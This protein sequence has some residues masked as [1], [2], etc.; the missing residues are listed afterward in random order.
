MFL[1]MKI[2]ETT[3]VKKRLAGNVLIDSKTDKAIEELEKGEIRQGTVKE[4]MKEI[5]KSPFISRV[6]V[7]C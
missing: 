6:R 7:Y 5:M 4:L 3:K 2:N 1:E